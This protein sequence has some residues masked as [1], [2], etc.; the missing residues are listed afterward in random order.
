MVIL[1]HRPR[2]GRGKRRKQRK[3][4]MFDFLK[5]LPK[6]S[7]TAAQKE[8]YENQMILL[9][10]E[11]AKAIEVLEAENRDLRS[12]VELVTQENKQLHMAVKTL[13]EQLRREKQNR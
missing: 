8:R 10:I 12:K 6:L 4:P 2:Q 11:H 9:K 13:E 1:F 5:F 7:L 3:R